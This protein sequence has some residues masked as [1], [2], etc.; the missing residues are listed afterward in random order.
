MSARMA[1]K[2]KEELK[3]IRKDKMLS[4]VTGHFKCVHFTYYEAHFKIIYS[5]LIPILTMIAAYSVYVSE[6]HMNCELYP[7]RLCRRR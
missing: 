7:N 2:R 5:F 3:V 6:A 1:T 4:L